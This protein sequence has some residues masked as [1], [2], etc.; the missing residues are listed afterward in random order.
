MLHLMNREFPILLNVFL[1]Q[2]ARGAVELI[3]EFTTNAKTLRLTGLLWTLMKTIITHTRR[4]YQSCLNMGGSN[5]YLQFEPEL[6][7]H[8]VD[9]NANPTPRAKQKL[10]PRSNLY[11]VFGITM[12]SSSSWIYIEVVGSWNSQCP[13]R[14]HKTK[15]SQSDS[16]L[17][18]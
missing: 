9:V 4:K 15:I 18:V 1:N 10:S 16:T 2:S 12:H 11:W 17:W 3:R 5:T 13:M 7:W 6:E 8:H 14:F